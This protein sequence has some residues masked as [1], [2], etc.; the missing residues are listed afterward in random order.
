M[1]RGTVAE[2]LATAMAAAGVSRAQLQK[3][4]PIDGKHL[5]RLLKGEVGLGARKAEQLA[6]ALKVTAAHLLVIDEGDPTLMA[7]V[8]VDERGLSPYAARMGSWFEDLP[9][10]V[11]AVTYF[12]GACLNDRAEFERLAEVARKSLRRMGRGIPVSQG[13]SRK[14]PAA[15]TRG[16]RQKKVS[17]R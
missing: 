6:A 4:A 13:T 5:R 17:G 11:Q 9:E 12:L 2:R 1:P 15:A 14:L 10:D 3:L 16:A 7:P 8:L